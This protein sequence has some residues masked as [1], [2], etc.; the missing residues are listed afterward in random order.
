ML[1]GKKKLAPKILG[2]KISF[3][4]YLFSYD[5]GNLI[6]LFKRNDIFK[7]GQQRRVLLQKSNRKIVV[8]QIQTYILKIFI[9]NCV[10]NNMYYIIER[11]MICIRDDM[12][13]IYDEMCQIR[14]DTSKYLKFCFCMQF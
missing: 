5:Q 7:N 12:L 8:L 1:R 4:N 9:A 3:S 13:R 11:V 10:L 14:F 2:G 6:I